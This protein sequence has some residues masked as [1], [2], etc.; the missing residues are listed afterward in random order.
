MVG[1][2]LLL[3]AASIT[4]CLL[5]LLVSGLLLVSIL[6]LTLRL[7]CA[8]RHELHATLFH[9]HLQQRCELAPVGKLN[10][11]AKRNT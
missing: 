9:I 6:F 7:S 2:L 8:A 4:F 5:L 1:V 10:L 3:L 11:L